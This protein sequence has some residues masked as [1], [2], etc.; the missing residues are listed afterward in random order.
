MVV[1]EA[2]QGGIRSQV[3]FVRE[4]PGSCDRNIEHKG[5][6]FAALITRGENLL[7]AYAGSVPPVLLDSCD[8][9]I[10]F[11]LAQI[12]FRHKSRYRPSVPGDNQS[13]SLLDLIEQLKQTSLCF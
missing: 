4:G 9:L 13:G 7:K 11:L 5:H 1:S 6:L 2:S 12:C 3:V 8:S 10:D